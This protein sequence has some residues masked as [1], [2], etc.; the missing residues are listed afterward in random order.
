[1]PSALEERMVKERQ[2]SR[3][4][5]KTSE[6]PGTSGSHEGG[7]TRRMPGRKAPNEDPSSL[8]TLRVSENRKGKSKPKTSEKTGTSGSHEGGRTRRT[9]GRKAPN[10]DPYSLSTLRVSGNR[11]GKSK[12]KSPHPYGA[13]PSQPRLSESLEKDDVETDENWTAGST[14]PTVRVS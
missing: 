5:R 1:M 11:K 13:R 4:K 7:R 14:A 9:P 6:K 10:E 8:S 3:S 12:P 2:E